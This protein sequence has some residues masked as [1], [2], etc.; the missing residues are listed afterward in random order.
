[1]K[2]IL[3]LLLLLLLATGSHYSAPAQIVYKPGELNIG[4]VTNHKDGFINISGLNGGVWKSNAGQFL[5]IDLT[6]RFPA[7][8]GTNDRIDIA[9]KSHGG[10]MYLPFYANRV[11]SYWNNN[12]LTGNNALLYANTLKTATFTDNSGSRRYAL[13][14]DSIDTVSLICTLFEAVNELRNTA[15]KQMQIIESLES[16]I[17]SQNSLQ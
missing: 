13:R 1:M 16:N 10:V 9:D 17:A 5:K 3:K 7:I 2:K 4:S 15:A 11:Y 14:S 12:Y 8:A 6:G